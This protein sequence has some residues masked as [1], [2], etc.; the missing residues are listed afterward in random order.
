MH[1]YWH[2]SYLLVIFTLLALLYGLWSLE[3]EYDVAAPQNPELH[4][5]PAR[6]IQNVQTGMIFHTGNYDDLTWL[7]KPIWQPPLDLWLIQEAIFEVKP[8]LIIE[9]GTYKGGSSYFF[10]QVLDLLGEGRVVTIDIERQHDLNHPRVTYLLGDSASPQ[11]LEEVR[12]EASKTAG[13]IMVILDSDHS[14][15]HVLRELEAYHDF[16][17]PGSYLHVQDGVIDVLPIFSDARPGPLRAIEEFLETNDEF[18][19]DLERSNK[20]LISHHPKGWLRR[21]G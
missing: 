8:G 3:S 11:I 6:E 20:F 18:E 16:V 13:P 15:A 17:T 2:I 7:G 21:N 1:R 12:A 14:M 9:C 19:L 10:G 5:I 4:A